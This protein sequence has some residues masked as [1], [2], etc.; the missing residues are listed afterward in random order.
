MISIWLLSHQYR[1]FL[2]KFPFYIL[3]NC[4]SVMSGNY[5]YTHFDNVLK[6]H[7]CLGTLV[8]NK[9]KPL[10]L[11]RKPVL[12]LIVIHLHRD[13]W[14]L[15]CLVERAKIFIAITLKLK[16]EVFWH[17]R[18]TFIFPQ[19]GMTMFTVDV[20]AVT[21]WLFKGFLMVLLTNRTI[22]QSQFEYMLID[23]AWDFKR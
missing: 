12:G 23:V 11:I 14:L 2:S 17:Q 16:A 22:R 6:I 9:L 3:L 20:C 4:F 7:F 10:A 5:L 18:A 21:V 1:I 13:Q 19:T 15:N 8:P